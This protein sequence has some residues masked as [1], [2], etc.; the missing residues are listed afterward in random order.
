MDQG[1][2]FHVGPKRPFICGTLLRNSRPLEALWPD[3]PGVATV[4]DWLRLS[5]SHPSGADGA[6]GGGL[7]Q[8]VSPPLCASVFPSIRL[9]PTALSSAAG[10]E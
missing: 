5:C 7:L 2:S 10:R 6:D 8:D 3:R 4:P 9:R 1:K